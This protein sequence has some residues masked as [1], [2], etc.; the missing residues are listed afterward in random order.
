[1]K[2]FAY[3]LVGEVEQKGQIVKRDLMLII[4]SHTYLLS[5]AT[6]EYIDSLH[7]YNRPFEEQLR[8]DEN[9]LAIDSVEDDEHVADKISQ[10][11]WEIVAPYLVEQ[12]EAE[13]GN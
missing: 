6:P 11:P 5:V 12:E 1:M 10:M 8:I 3:Q 9:I 13:T 4:D 7:E 2:E